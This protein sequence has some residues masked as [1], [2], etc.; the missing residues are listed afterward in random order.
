M[1]N[2]DGRF[3]LYSS[4]N[5]NHLLMIELINKTYSILNNRETRQLTNLLV[6]CGTIT[7]ELTIASLESKRSRKESG[8]E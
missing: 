8:I 6:T 1:E 5:L 3:T 2:R 4:L 7:K